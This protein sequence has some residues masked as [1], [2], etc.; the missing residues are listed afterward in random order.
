MTTERTTQALLAT[1]AFLLGVHLV[2]STASVPIAGAQEVAP[3]L[4][5]QAIELV[6]AQGL[7]V[8]QLYTGD[9]GGGDL[10]LRSG[11]GVVRVKLGATPDGS[12][13]LLL[14]RDVEP[15]IVLGSNAG[16][17]R[18]TLAQQGRRKR[19]IRPRTAQG[20]ALT[21]RTVNVRRSPAPRP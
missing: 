13:L 7:T 18:V 10:R 3:V 6:N 21:R 20:A 1:V 5:A 4:R 9:D 19:V 8:A 11:E 15:A 14:D 16:E 2:R 17:T 12:G